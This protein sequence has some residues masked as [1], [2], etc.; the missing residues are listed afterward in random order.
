MVSR[1]IALFLSAASIGL[2]GC[3]GTTGSDLVEF[4]AAAAG[5][6]DAV[7]GQSYE[8]TSGRGYHVV[9][10]RAVVHIGAVYL[11]LARPVSGAQA[12][13]CILPG[14]YVG[15]VIKGLDVDALSP[16]PQPFPIAGEGTAT[17]AITGEV[18]LTGG[19][20]NAED[21]STVIL[22]VAGTADAAGI[23]YPFDGKLTI[24]KNRAVTVGDPSLPS[25]HPICK[26][27]IV[28][29]IAVDI[30]PKA[31]GT[32]L[33]RVDPKGLFTNVDFSHMDKVSDAPPHYVFHDDGGTP[34]DANL[35]RGLQA[36]DGVYQLMWNDST[37][38]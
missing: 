36:R 12:T 35:F 31:G 7:K 23:S 17:R 15:E 1:T 25:Q 18:W 37:K 34:P 10:T 32:L 13:D 2:A 33:V 16:D 11:N 5:P 3:V 28:S 29:P 26:E 21:D 14:I 38:H 20:V 9:L 27:R 30:T 22:D 24:G 19:D 6:A 8:F 4:S